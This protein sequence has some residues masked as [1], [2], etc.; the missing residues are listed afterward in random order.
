MVRTTIQQEVIETKC[1]QCGKVCEFDAVTVSFGYGSKFDMD[2]WDFCS[3][4]CFALHVVE[5]LQRKSIIDNT[6]VSK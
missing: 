1:D 2:R 3:D 6:K 5:K 4:N